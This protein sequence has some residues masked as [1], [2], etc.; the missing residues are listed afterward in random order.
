MVMCILAT[1]WLSGCATLPTAE[2]YGKKTE[3]IQGCAT[4]VLAAIL[5]LPVIGFRGFEDVCKQQ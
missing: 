5:G 4:K 1:A 3:Q 2:E